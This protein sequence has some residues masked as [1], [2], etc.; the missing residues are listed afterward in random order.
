MAH[1]DMR[2]RSVRPPPMCEGIQLGMVYETPMLCYWICPVL[3][4][5]SRTGRDRRTDKLVGLQSTY[6][7]QCTFVESTRTEDGV[8]GTAVIHHSL[9]MCTRT[10]IHLLNRL[11]QHQIEARG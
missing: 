9:L 2:K 8:K 6:H 4:N 5:R 3:V 11:Y 1:N 7:T 10:C